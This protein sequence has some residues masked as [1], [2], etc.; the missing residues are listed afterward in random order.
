MPKKI[1]FVQNCIKIHR[2]KFYK[3]YYKITTLKITLLNLVNLL[4]RVKV[5]PKTKKSASC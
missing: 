5:L 1:V 3:N 4:V 2:L